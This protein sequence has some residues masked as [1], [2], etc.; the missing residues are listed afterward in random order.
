M[1]LLVVAIGLKMPRWVDEAFAEY[2]KRMPRSARLELVE[3]RPEPRV[4]A[5]TVEQM[6]GLEAERI[7]AAVPDRAK[8]VALDERGREFT[9]AALARWL[10][11]RL[12]EGIDT[13]FLIGGPDGL[14]APLKD[15]AETVMRLSAMTLP[16]GLARVLLAEQLYR[17]VSILQNHPYHRE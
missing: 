7:A 3:V 1:R 15:K 10:A 12:Q 4:E 17:A 13:A 9:S 2:A 16:H 14:A 6:L 5:R 11:R 8:T